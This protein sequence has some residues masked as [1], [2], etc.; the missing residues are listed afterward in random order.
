M[1]SY[2][3]FTA[4]SPA[5]G[6]LTQTG[7]QEPSPAVVILPAVAGLNPYISQVANQLAAQGYASL[8]LDYYAEAGAA[9]DLSDR[10]KITAAV[11][12]LSEH[13]ILNDV[14]A[15]IDYLKE[16]STVNADRIAVLGFCIGGTYAILSASRF[17]M[18]TCVISFYGTLK[19][20]AASDDKRH[21]PIDALA[22]SSC[23]IL[24]HYGETDSLIPLEHVQEM[25]KRLRT[26]PAEIYTYPGAGH[27]FHEHVRPEV[28]RPV[29]AKESWQRTLDYLDWYCKNKSVLQT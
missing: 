11:E 7:R 5:G 8:A 23:P 4:D 18:L 13:K 27:A 24:G 17:D 2:I 9:P 22:H 21:S 6:I 20:A 10:A 15:G 29:A 1:G 26:R 28:Y 16:Q 3:R 14:S 25:R 12:S 19:Y